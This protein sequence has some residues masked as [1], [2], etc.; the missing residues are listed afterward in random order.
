M[1]LAAVK[2]FP[3]YFSLNTRNIR[4]T[5]ENRDII[6]SGYRLTCDFYYVLNMLFF[7]H[8][9]RF[10]HSFPVQ[11]V[12]GPHALH[13]LHQQELMFCQGSAQLILQN[14]V[15]QLLSEMFVVELV[16]QTTES[17]TF[18]S[19]FN[20]MHCVP[21]WCVKLSNSLTPFCF[22][23]ISQLEVLR[24]PSLPICYHAFF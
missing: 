14:Q 24:L 7:Q 21:V 15:S 5:V 1:T 20:S 12:F 2:L 23:L 3:Q 8:E 19:V 17:A 4:V 18:F 22:F 16:R 10:A 9:Q 13:L 11:I 6:L